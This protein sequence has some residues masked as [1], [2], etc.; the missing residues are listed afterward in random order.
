M[1]H[2]IPSPS[3]SGRRQA[4]LAARAREL[5]CGLNTPQQMLWRAVAAGR[6]GVSF[7]REVALIGRYIV[8]MLAP[9]LRLVVE[10]D[11]RCHESRRRADTRR[12]KAL[13]AAGYHVLRLEARIV[14]SNLPRA[15]ARVR[16]EVVRLSV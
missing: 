13:A 14:L 5:R 12:D 11:G 8:D 10:I 15:V 6:L 2:L 7:R 1:R 9:S 16:E 3:V 4:L